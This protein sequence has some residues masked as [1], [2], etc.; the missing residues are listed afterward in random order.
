MKR[1]VN[2]VRGNEED[3]RSR[4]EMKRSGALWHSILNCAVP[5]P[6]LDEEECNVEG[7]VAPARHSVDSKPERAQPQVGMSKTSAGVSIAW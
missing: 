7:L 3:N 4:R 6:D 5:Y 1:V 2:G